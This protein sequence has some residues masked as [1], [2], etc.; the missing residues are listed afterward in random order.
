MDR[1]FNDD[2][3]VLCITYAT[4]YLYRLYEYMYMYNCEFVYL[5]Y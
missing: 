4:D 1:G 3:Y 2:V 5:Y